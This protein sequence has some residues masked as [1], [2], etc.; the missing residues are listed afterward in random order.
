M[1]SLSDRA[2]IEGKKKPSLNDEFPDGFI[3]IARVMEKY[4]EVQYRYLITPSSDILATVPDNLE[5]RSDKI[6]Q[7]ALEGEKDAFAALEQGPGFA[8]DKLKQNLA[9]YPKTDTS[10][11]NPN[12]L[13]KAIDV[14][15]IAKEYEKRLS[16]KKT[17]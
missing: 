8:F 17:L 11:S 15:N 7:L 10:A 16:E 12:F 13:T 1:V 9:R 6:K 4:P 14:I 2:V 5:Y 3:E